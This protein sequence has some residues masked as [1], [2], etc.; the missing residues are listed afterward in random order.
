MNHDIPTI[1]RNYIN[2]NI[3]INL[4]KM[5]GIKMELKF[6]TVDENLLP[7]TFVLQKLLLQYIF[8]FTK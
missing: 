6:R 8:F 2:I 3:N 7:V 5:H 1:R 4:N